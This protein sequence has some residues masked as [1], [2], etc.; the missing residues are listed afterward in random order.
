MADDLDPIDELEEN[1]GSEQ[2][3]YNDRQYQ[4]D[5]VKKMKRLEAE[6]ATAKAEAAEAQA[7]RKENLFLKA[8]V[9][10]IDSGV[11]K[12]LFNG[13]DGELTVDAIKAAAS[14]VNLI[15]TSQQPDVAAELDALSGTRQVSQSAS[16]AG[17]PD[18][19]T[20]IKQK[21]LTR[22]QII[23]LAVQAGSRISDEEPG[24]ISSLV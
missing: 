24:A 14:E 16:G 10:N 9:G 15:P 8:G 22:Q 3:Q 11:G 21:G 13:Y 12:L 18:F 19:V 2:S 23:D 7:I 4:R 5:Q 20:Q 6:N 17:T 1:E